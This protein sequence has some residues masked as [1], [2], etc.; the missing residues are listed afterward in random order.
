[1]EPPCSRIPTPVV[2]CSVSV[3]MS[4]RPPSPLVAVTDDRGYYTIEDIPVYTADREITYSVRASADGFEPDSQS[5]SPQYGV[6]DSVFFVLIPGV[7]A[8][9]A[10]RTSAGD[11]FEAEYLPGSGLLHVVVSSEQMLFL[12]AF[13]MTGRRIDKMCSSYRLGR[14]SHVLPRDR[15]GAA[16]GTIVL[17]VSGPGGH[18]NVHITD[19]TGE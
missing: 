7:S 13:S 15:T 12:E 9:A 5:A 3:K 14:G 6:V 2:G 19:V 11:M 18:Q 4:V 10:R 8:V 1:M 17:R 16:S